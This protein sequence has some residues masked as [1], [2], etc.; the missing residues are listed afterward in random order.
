MSCLS[1]SQRRR[2]NKVMMKQATTTILSRRC[3]VC[4]HDLRWYD[5]HNITPSFA[6]LVYCRGA[7][8]RL[9]YWQISACV[10]CGQRVTKPR[11]LCA[12]VEQL[13]AKSSSC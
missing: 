10:C 13:Y 11:V 8:E 5:T 12:T 9:R 4:R 7:S 6:F 2:R 1:G 3:D